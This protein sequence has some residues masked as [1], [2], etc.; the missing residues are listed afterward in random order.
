MKVIAVGNLYGNDS[1]MDVVVATGSAAVGYKATISA[2]GAINLN[3]QGN[4]ATGTVD[5]VAV[6]DFNGDLLDD[7]VISGGT[8]ASSVIVYYNLGGG[9]F[10]T[11]GSSAE[12][13]AGGEDSPPAAGTIDSGTYL[14]TQTEDSSCEMLKEEQQ[15]QAGGVTN[16]DPTTESSLGPAQIISGSYSNVGAAAAGD[17]V[18]E[19]IWYG[20]NW[21]LLQNYTVGSL[22][23]GGVSWSLKIEAE[24]TGPS[25][26]T[27]GGAIDTF[28]VKWSWTGI[29]GW[30]DFTT[31]IS[32]DGT[33]ASGTLKSF[34]FPSGALDG[35]TQIYLQI[36][37]STKT[38]QGGKNQGSEELTIY[39]CY[40]AT[41]TNDTWFSYLE[42]EW[43]ISVGAGY[44]LYTF[45]LR[46]NQSDTNETEKYSFQYSV[47]NRVT[48]KD[49]TEP[50]E[51]YQN[52]LTDFENFAFQSG[53]SPSGVTVYIRATNIVL[54]TTHLDYL[55]VDFMQIKGVTAGGGTVVGDG[56]AVEVGDADGDGDPDVFTA[57]DGQMYV[58]Q[59]NGTT[60][61]S[62]WS[63][64]DD[65][66]DS[67][68]SDTIDLHANTE[69][70]C[71]RVADMNGDGFADM[72]VTADDGTSIGVIYIFHANGAGE[73]E[74]IMAVDVNA[75][76][77]EGIGAKLD[78]DILGIDVGQS[79]GGPD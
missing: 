31:S 61:A 68:I 34:D 54:G 76:S 71:F 43:S 21:Q 6:A 13:K 41:T 55:G 20:G 4:I 48:F 47:D 72:V 12:Y 79:E 42:Q 45:D 28:S 24:I 70:D 2:L 23:E 60:G 35:K 37:D 8:A 52:S 10:G 46:A 9:V 63:E 74:G 25:S 49:F 66:D 15:F 51:V 77:Y 17:E 57:S 1:L 7:V 62:A 18:M 73:W 11:G 16:D 65:P 36:E 50:L 22:T 64:L 59:N 44:S 5:D 3:S 69:A 58:Y 14:T 33:W 19:E 38:D 30:T 39:K 75:E 26:G 40:V 29:S 32:I 27:G 56:F 78:N 53:D 67:G